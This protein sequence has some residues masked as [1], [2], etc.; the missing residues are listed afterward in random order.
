MRAYPSLYSAGIVSNH[1]GA[2]YSSDMLSHV[3]VRP[4][5]NASLAAASHAELA[6]SSDTSGYMP[7][8]LDTH[9]QTL[10][11]AGTSSAL[12]QAGSEAMTGGWSEGVRGQGGASVQ[13]LMVQHSQ[14]GGP[15][16]MLEPVEEDEGA[17]DEM[18]AC[19]HEVHAMSLLDPV[20]DKQVCVVPPIQRSLRACVCAST[21]ACVL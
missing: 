4:P 6:R 21:H 19:F 18:Q 15:P 2:G 12:P 14:A 11:H 20:L 5:S 1:E 10:G 13:G 17:Y 3:G 16:S 7:P 8:P 9:V